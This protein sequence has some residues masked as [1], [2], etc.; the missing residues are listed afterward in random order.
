M[1]QIFNPI[2]EKVVLGNRHGHAGN[3][4]FLERIPADQIIR[5]VGSNGHHRNTVHKCGCDTGHQIGGTRTAGGENHTGL[6]CCSGIAVCS[7][8]RA[9]LMGSQYMMDPVA[10]FVQFIKDVQR[11][12][13][14]I[15]EDGIYTMVQ[16]NFC[17]NL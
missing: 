12:A 1:L 16:Q 11:G 17:H 2:Y 5:Y 14:R 6:S 3:A 9:L 7:M 4:D 10:V 15:A 8:G 13:A